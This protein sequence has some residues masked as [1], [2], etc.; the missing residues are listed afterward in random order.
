MHSN[1]QALLDRLDHLVALQQFEAAEAAWAARDGEYRVP[2]RLW[3][4]AARVA[5]G[6]EDWAQAEQRWRA[7]LEAAPDRLVSQVGLARALTA[8]GRWAEAMESIN[9][10]LEA[11]PGR[12]P[13]W[14]LKAKC[15]WHLGDAQGSLQAAQRVLAHD[16]NRWPM[17]EWVARSATKLQQPVLALSAW[18]VLQ[19]RERFEPEASLGVLACH[20]QLG[21]HPQAFAVAQALLAQPKAPLRVAK[22]VLRAARRF[23][24][25]ALAQTV[26]QRLRQAEPEA[27][28]WALAEASVHLDKLEFAQARECLAQPENLPSGRA[29]L[30]TAMRATLGQADVPFLAAHVVH[31]LLHT[32]LVSAPGGGKQP[33][34]ALVEALVL[35]VGEGWGEALEMALHTL[36]QQ[37]DNTTAVAW[38]PLLELALCAAR[39]QTLPLAANLHPM[40][41]LMVARLL[42]QQGWPDVALQALDAVNIEAARQLWPVAD[43][44]WQVLVVRYGALIRLGQLDAALAVLRQAELEGEPREALSTR[45]A[46]ICLHGLKAPGFLVAWGEQA[47]PAD[48]WRW[49][50]PAA[51]QDHVLALA[52]VNV[53]E[54][55][56]GLPGLLDEAHRRVALRPLNVD[57]VS[58]LAGLLQADSQYAAAAAAFNPLLQSV[59]ARPWRLSALDAPWHQA[60]A[61]AVV[62]DE[63]QAAPQ[64]GAEPVVSVLLN[65]EGEDAAV[66]AT[67]QAVLAQQGVALEVLLAHADDWP[68]A[69]PLTAQ[70][71]AS[72]ARVRTVAVPLWQGPGHAR[73]HV[74]QQ[75]QA[76]LLAL[77]APGQWWHPDLLAVQCAALQANPDWVAVRPRAL[78]VGPGLHLQFR[79]ER[80]LQPGNCA[81]M[82][83]RRTSLPAPLNRFNTQSQQ[84]DALWFQALQ[85]ALGPVR[86]GDVVAPLVVMPPNP[87]LAWYGPVPEAARELAATRCGAGAAP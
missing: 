67:L 49:A 23:G 13:M 9:R 32:E 2:A 20:T 16:A 86:L 59:G 75:A 72:D 74:V 33:A 57:L 34:A 37:A 27:P 22:G 15:L 52:A 42:L 73:N 11:E 30:M 79:P 44:R 18:Q 87:Q 82:L 65:V 24:D 40:Q 45:M 84:A 47:G 21:Q 50:A 53:A 5:E 77:A 7:S 76:P 71:A 68:A 35:L 28:Q 48:A 25:H 81:A 83:W 69:W 46:D 78:R 64:A 12:I 60:G 54:G 6:L 56:A 29:T 31:A 19:T 10:V 8:L 41:G 38:V 4:E 43:V 1:A 51:V 36:Q 39:G 61:L 3:D 17:Q 62:A 63:L 85:H 26:V 55:S 58:T 66:A 70:V 80:P 14:A